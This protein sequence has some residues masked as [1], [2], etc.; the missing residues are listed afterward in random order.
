MRTVA[1][2][3]ARGGSKGLPRKNIYPLCGRPLIAWSIEQALA[4]E[5]IEQVIVS[6]DDEAVEDVVA[7]MDVSLFWRS[8]ATATDEATSESAL[9]EVCRNV[10]DIT[11]VVFLQATSPVRD[12]ADIDAAYSTYRAGQWD[13]VFSARRVEGYTWL[14]HDGHVDA[15]W[16]GN[17]CRRQDKDWQLWEETGSFYVLSADALL[18]TGSRFGGGATYQATHPLDGYQLDSRDDVPLL[19]AAMRIRRGDCVT[20]VAH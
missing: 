2:I 13:C 5:C 12:P 8:A 6:T 1:I 4:T 11:T 15:S 10:P 17:R 14:E 3:P 19:E 16:I 20:A 9:I 7:Q 18:R